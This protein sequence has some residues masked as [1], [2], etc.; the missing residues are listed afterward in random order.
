MPGPRHLLSGIPEPSTS[1]AWQTVKGDM[2]MAGD[3]SGKLAS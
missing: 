3:F 2:L 1:K